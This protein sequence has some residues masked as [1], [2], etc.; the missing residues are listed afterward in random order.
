MNS[1][2]RSLARADA[3]GLRALAR[4]CDEALGTDE[5]PLADRCVARLA[6]DEHAPHTA[7]REDAHGLAAAG[8]IDW[9]RGGEP[10]ALLRAF[11]RPDARQLE[12]ELIEMLHDRAVRLLRDEPAEHPRWVRADRV[13]RGDASSL[14][15]GT[16]DT[17]KRLGLTFLYVEHE[18]RRPL[19]PLPV[20]VVFPNRIRIE[21][22]TR[23]RDAAIREAYNAAFADRGFAGY[24]IAEW[25]TG[26]FSGQ[27]SFRPELSFLALEGGTISG[28][29][30][31]TVEDDEP[32][33]GWID[34]VGVGPAAR[35]RGIADGLLFAAMRAMYAAGLRDAALRVNDDNPRARRVYD[36]L[37]FTTGRKHVVYR[38]PAEP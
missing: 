4:A 3:E 31:C 36:R 20:P 30:L 29:V 1:G 23:E 10:R 16:L 11:A 26:P 2:W 35:S 15:P 37:G 27:E 19:D 6:R 32:H 7:A 12:D 22:W 17:Y 24:G 13:L 38:K 14:P 8:W 18:M 34:T 9:L 25:A 28:F 33:T 5:E 21:R